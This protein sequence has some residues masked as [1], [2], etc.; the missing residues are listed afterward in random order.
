MSAIEN[1]SGSGG[2][3]SAHGESGGRSEKVRLPVKLFWVV[4]VQQLNPWQQL[5]GVRLHLWT[6]V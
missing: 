2:F 5:F 1:L 3:V 4:G 6:E